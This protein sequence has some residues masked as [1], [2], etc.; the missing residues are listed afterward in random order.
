ML[1]EGATTSADHV[2]L[3]RAAEVR[4]ERETTVLCVGKGTVSIVL[5]NHGRQK[6]RNDVLFY[7][8]FTSTVCMHAADVQSDTEPLVD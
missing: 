2:E 4:R 7:S 8:I 1:Q 3:L 6:I 5:D